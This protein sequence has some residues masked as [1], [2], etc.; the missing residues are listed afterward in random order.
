VVH[1]GGLFFASDTPLEQNYLYHLDANGRVEECAVLPSSSIYACRN[2]SGM[3]FSTM[4]EPSYVNRGR[5][6]TIFGSSSGARWNA[7]AQW[8]KDLWSMKYFQY[9]NALLPDGENSSDLLALTTVA[10]AGV[11]LT[12][13][14]W[15]TSTT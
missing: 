10:V 2:C 9:G 6:V 14:I 8:R 13:S 1:E 12:T 5:D 7:L 11:D 4:I 15:K 3:F